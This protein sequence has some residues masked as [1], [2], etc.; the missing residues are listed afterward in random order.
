MN[1]FFGH[2][3]WAT[4]NGGGGNNPNRRATNQQD[5]RLGCG[6][7]EDD[8]MDFDFA[9]EWEGGI[10]QGGAYPHQGMSSMDYKARRASIFNPRGVE[11][12][13]GQQQPPSIQDILG[14]QWPPAQPDQTVTQGGGQQG[15]LGR[16][17]PSRSGATS[18]AGCTN[19]GA[20][21]RRNKC[22]PTNRR[23][24]SHRPW[25]S[26]LLGHKSSSRTAVSIWHD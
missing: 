24:R 11:Q 21:I 9:T 20:T 10:P 14:G 17:A 12:H 6:S 2:L 23:G 22:T 1:G 5:T 4:E 19:C 8:T 7:Y 3:P 16:G 26:A 25:R 15:A 13:Q 18:T